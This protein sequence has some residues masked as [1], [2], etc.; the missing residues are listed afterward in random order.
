MHDEPLPSKL[1]DDPERDWAALTSDSPTDK[2]RQI[3]EL[4]EKLV[5]EIDARKEDRF[6]FVVV[7]VLLFNIM[8][9][10]SME[11]TS[12]PIAILILELLVLLPLARAG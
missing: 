7:C 3:L 12:G 5:A 1:P 10:S 2:D 8:I 6:F 11:N 4:Q 9:F